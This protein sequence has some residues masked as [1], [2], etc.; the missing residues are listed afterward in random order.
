MNPDNVP[1]PSIARGERP[2][3]AYTGTPQP[4]GTFVAIPPAPPQGSPGVRTAHRRVTGLVPAQAG[5][6]FP[7][8]MR[9][10]PKQRIN[11]ADVSKTRAEL[12]RAQSTA[13]TAEAQWVATANAQNPTGDQKLLLASRD[14][15]DLVAALTRKL[16]EYEALSASRPTRVTLA[17]VR[18][19]SEVADVI[20]TD[21]VYVCLHDGCKG[22]RWPDEA[23]MRRAH[24]SD[25]DMAR[26]QA[27]H[28]FAILCDA[29]LDP[30]DP[31]GEIVGL[32]APVGRDGTTIARAVAESEK[33]DDD[34]ETLR[35][36]NATLAERLGKLEALLA[37]LTPD[38]AKGKA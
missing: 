8:V 24:P 25:A 11:P 30:L 10:Q 1:A 26:V 33:A 16:G 4:V 3:L 34:I 15:T 35:A 9:E 38:K 19:P 5:A 18:E 28:P 27:C 2:S 17:R 14:A 21:G 7:L 31:E 36:E 6:D 12:R 20:G 32:V 29:P 23:A 22:H 13:R 37:G